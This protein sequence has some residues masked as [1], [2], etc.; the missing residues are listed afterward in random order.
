[1][2]LHYGLDPTLGYHL[3][4]AYICAPPASKASPSSSTSTSSSSRSK[5]VPS[6]GKPGT[7]DRERVLATCFSQFVDW[8]EG[9]YRLFTNGPSSIAIYFV[10]GDAF[11]FCTS[12]VTNNK[13]I[14]SSS[15]ARM[16]VTGGGEGEGGEAAARGWSRLALHAL[17]P[18]HAHP[19]RLHRHQQYQRPLWIAKCAVCYP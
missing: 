11:D 5:P 3:A 1:M 19:V 15:Q 16:R 6:S 17:P 2:N 12:V 10:V 9:L 13:I 14:N 4:E 7:V 18:P 8:C